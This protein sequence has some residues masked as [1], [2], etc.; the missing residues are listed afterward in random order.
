MSYEYNKFYCVCNINIVNVTVCEKY[1]G[2][3]VIA[4]PG[5]YSKV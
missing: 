1:N 2:Y 5:A 3:K 4:F